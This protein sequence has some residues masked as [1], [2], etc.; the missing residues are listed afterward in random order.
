VSG[1]AQDPISPRP[2]IPDIVQATWT[3]NYV[4]CRGCQNRARKGKGQ[5]CPGSK[6][7]PA[8]L[9][10]G[11]LH[12]RGH[13]RTP[14]AN[15]AHMLRNVNGDR[16]STKLNPRRVLYADSSASTSF[17]ANGRS[18]DDRGSPGGAS[19]CGVADTGAAAG[20][21]GE[22]GKERGPAPPPSALPP[23]CADMPDAPPTATFSNPP[24]EFLWSIMSPPAEGP[25]RPPKTRK[26][27]PPLAAKF[28]SKRLQNDFK[29]DRFRASIIGGSNRGWA[30]IHFPGPDSRKRMCCSWKWSISNL[31][32]RPREPDC[33]ILGHLGT[34]SGVGALTEYRATELRTP[35]AAS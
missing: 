12:R 10:T 22:A 27:A 34:G 35:S 7:R 25:L 32:L 11:Q 8:A 18:V 1:V 15:S 2:T 20:T 28:L 17:S 3:H 4:H 16:R 31:D 29:I 6:L 13:G 19:G 14:E 9:T 30:L 26:P 23:S 33:D 21:I 24:Y 5:R